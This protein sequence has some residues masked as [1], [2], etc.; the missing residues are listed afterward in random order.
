MTIV[1]DGI[2]LQEYLPTIKIPPS[3]YNKLLLQISINK[4]KTVRYKFYSQKSSRT[5]STY[6]RQRTQ[7]QQHQQYEVS[8]VPH[9][10]GIH[11]PTEDK[12]YMCMKNIILNMK[13]TVLMDQTLMRRTNIFSQT[14]TITMA[15]STIIRR[16]ELLKI[17]NVN[18]SH[19][20][21]ELLIYHIIMM[22]P[23]V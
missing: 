5:S 1:T 20:I 23:M 10:E 12:E 22:V 2:P 7:N 9:I 16:A 11:R 3:N 19:M 8:S 13:M 4:G 21:W 17:G 18:Q 15:K 14:G 6:G